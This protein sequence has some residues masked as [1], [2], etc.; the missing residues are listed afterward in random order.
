MQRGVVRLGFVQRK[1]RRGQ[2]PVVGA[3]EPGDEHGCVVAHPGL[4]LAPALEE[5]AL[6]PV[7]CAF[8]DDL[9]AGLVGHGLDQAREMARRILP[10]GGLRSVQILDRARAAGF[11][12]AGRA[13]HVARIQPRKTQ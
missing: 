10:E 7:A 12:R 2:A 3:P 1:P 4:G 5:L 9:G 8:Q 13:D 11:R 6:R